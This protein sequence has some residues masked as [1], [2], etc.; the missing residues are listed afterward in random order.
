MNVLALIFV[1]VVVPA[2]PRAATYTK[3]R[4]A[5]RRHREKEV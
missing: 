2:R 5:C 3:H 1:L 4:T